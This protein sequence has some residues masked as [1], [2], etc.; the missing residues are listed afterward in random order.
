MLRLKIGFLDSALDGESLSDLTFARPPMIETAEVS[1]W[2]E[3]T[4]L[5][6]RRQ[7]LDRHRLRR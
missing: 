7:V 4:F 2:L 1:A 3:S 5:I 6:G